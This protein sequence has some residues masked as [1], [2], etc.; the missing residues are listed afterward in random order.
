MPT[1]EIKPKVKMSALKRKLLKLHPGELKDSESR[2]ILNYIN[3]DP[4]FAKAWKNSTPETRKNK[5]K[6]PLQGY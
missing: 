5:M 6:G 2:M 3:S 4:E 1:K